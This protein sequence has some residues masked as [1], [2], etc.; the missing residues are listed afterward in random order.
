MSK[1]IEN[2]KYLTEQI[3]TYIGNKRSL[4][5]F[6]GEAVSIVQRDLDKE[7]LDIVDIFSGSG[8]VARYLKRFSNKIVTNDLENYSYTLNK[9][10]LSNKDEIDMDRIISYYNRLTEKLDEG[11]NKGFIT[12]LYAPK[13]S[14]NIKKGERVFYTTR[15]AKYIDTCRRIISTFPEDIQHYFIAPLLTEAS[16]KN[17]TGGVFKGFYKNKETGIGQFGGNGENALSRIKADIDIPFPTFSNYSCTVVNYQCDSNQLIDDLE[18]V[19]LI[20]MDPP[21]N[22]HPYGSNYF[23]LNLINDYKKPKEISEVS[24]IPKD[25]KRSKYNQKKESLAALN[26]LCSKAKAKYLLISFNSEGFITKKEM[27]HML[28]K[29]GYVLTMEKKYITYRASRNLTKR[30]TY[31]YEYLFLVKKF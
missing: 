12:E 23:M 10:Y 8:I 11:L 1:L 13:D 25:W 6:I 31:L 7:K 29:I 4:L 17:N 3:I 22:Q 30:N 20:Y 24:G 2:E 16:I 15:N 19:D 27:E 28:N 14:E 18:E 5:D 9:C 26:E 21:Y